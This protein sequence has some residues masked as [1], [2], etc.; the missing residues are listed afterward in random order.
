MWAEVQ[1]HSSMT[2][3]FEG[4]KGC[5]YMESN[6]LPLGRVLTKA[7]EHTDVSIFYLQNLYPA[8]LRK[9]TKL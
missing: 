1:K 5:L 3:I 9:K 4:A 6:G 8:Y 2:A 7:A